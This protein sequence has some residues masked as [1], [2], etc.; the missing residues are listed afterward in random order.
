MNKLESPLVFYVG[1][2]ELEML[3]KALTVH[4]EDYIILRIDNDKYEN[5]P[6]LVRIKFTIDNSNNIQM[7]E[8]I[9]H[10]ANLLR[11][12]DC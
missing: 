1:K 8:S 11:L 5:V 9:S 12:E 2:E 6:G 7:F 4:D 10:D 3:L